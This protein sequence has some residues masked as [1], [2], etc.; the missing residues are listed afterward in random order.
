MKENL[1]RVLDRM[2]T[3]AAILQRQDW[4]LADVSRGNRYV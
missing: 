4:I 2:G 1:D 3:G